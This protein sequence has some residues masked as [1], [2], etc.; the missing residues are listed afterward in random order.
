MSLLLAGPEAAADLTRLP[1]EVGHGPSH[2]GV[3]AHTAAYREGGPWL[4]ALLAGLDA[5]R[6]LLG[7]LLATYL[8]GVR[9]RPHE[10]TFLAWLDCRDL[11]LGDDPAAAFLEKGRVAVNSGPTF[12]PEGIQ[13]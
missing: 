3:A 8:P 1:E 5:N 9:W 11:G 13:L 2:L 7:D 12:G 4:D 6:R 10:G